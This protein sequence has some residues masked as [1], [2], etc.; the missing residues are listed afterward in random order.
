MRFTMTEKNGS[1]K[2]KTDIWGDKYTQHYDEDGKKTGTS[3]DKETLLFGDKYTQHNKSS[4]SA[5]G[6]SQS[7]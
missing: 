2:E 6:H 1:S 4:S 3:E 7:H 5:A